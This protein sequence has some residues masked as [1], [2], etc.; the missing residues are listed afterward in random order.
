MR[1]FGDAGDVE[2]AVAA[3]VDADVDVTTT[4]GTDT[5]RSSRW[6]RS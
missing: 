4:T 1:Q 5:L 3:P 2:A 6:G